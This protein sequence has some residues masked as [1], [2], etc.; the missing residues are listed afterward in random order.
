MSMT[1]ERYYLKADHQTEWREVT[2]DKFIDAEQ[3]EGF[4]PKPGCGPVATS[5]FTGDVISGR[6]DYCESQSITGNNQVKEF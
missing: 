1:R 3:A 6:V 5:G 2:Q 4:R